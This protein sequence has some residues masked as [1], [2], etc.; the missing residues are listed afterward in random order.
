MINDMGNGQA[1][2][3]LHSRS[4]N[5]PTYVFKLPALV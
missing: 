1:C 4:T 2:I 5:Q 3:V